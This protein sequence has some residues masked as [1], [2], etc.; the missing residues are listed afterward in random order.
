MI[1]F[2]NDL[3]WYTL[4]SKNHLLEYN[5]YDGIHYQLFIAIRILEF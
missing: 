3:K 2:N 5:A 1:D 4:N